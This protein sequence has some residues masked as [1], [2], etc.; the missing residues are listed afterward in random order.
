MPGRRTLGAKRPTNTSTNTATASSTGE[1]A[2]S[3]NHHPRQASQAEI[4]P[5]SSGLAAA[6]E[7]DPIFSWLIPNG[8]RRRAR[9][10]LFFRLEL[11]HVVLPAG[12]VWTTDASAGASLELPPGAWKMP[13]S[14]QLMHG[15]T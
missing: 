6:F 15:P 12:R 7:D 2:V 1:P 4:D 9:L 14:T 8:A 13:I 3:D 11:E 10:I 5:L